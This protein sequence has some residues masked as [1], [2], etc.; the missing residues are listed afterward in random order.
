M[1]KI[2]I[3]YRRQDTRQ[4]AGRIFDRLEAKFGR[5]HVFM[6]IDS[7]PF[8]VDFHEFLSKQVG[9]AE[10]VLALIGHDWADVRDEAS[11]RRLDN[12][13]DFVRIEIEAALS[14]GIPLGA[15]LIDGAPMP[16]PEQLPESMRTLTRR[17]AA[18]VDSGRDFN[19]HMNRLIADL[20]R[21]LN[22]DIHRAGRGSPESVQNAAERDRTDGRIKID[23][24]IPHGVEGGWFLPGAGKTEWFQDFAEGPEMV[25]IP[26]GK[27]LMGSPEKEPGRFG[28]EGPEH[29]VTIS[30]SF[31]IGR[32]AVTFEEWDYAQSDKD[33]RRITGLEPRKPE[34]EGWGR[35]NR[36]VIDVSWDDAH[37]YMK[38]LSAKTGHEYR[39]PYEAEWEY[40]ARAGTET[41][42]WWGAS[43]TPDQANYDGNYPYGDSKK[44]EF[45]GRILP[46]DR[47]EPNPWGL[48]QVQGNVWEWCADDRREYGEVAVARPSWFPGERPARASRRLMVLRG[49]Q[50]ARCPSHCAPPRR[51]AQHYRLPLRPS[52]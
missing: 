14:R 28:D 12:P 46:V 38:W 52:S 30:K 48:Y 32:Y 26:P 43:I 19:T 31:A 50:C 10:T 33:W 37:A 51:P 40:A 41:P 25:V 22:G 36:P 11:N 3:S 21:H 13:D 9:R 45:R 16:R 5:D 17:N 2:F 39:L 20:E 27:F 4:I 1:T 49:A 15:V 18:F 44:G 8:G 34:D 35:G 6:D 24:A 42:F 29:E 23:A 7:I 47:F